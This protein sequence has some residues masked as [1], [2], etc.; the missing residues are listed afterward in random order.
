[1]LG[2]LL[3]DKPR[4]I[5]SHDVVNHCRR[6]LGTRRVGH[7]GTLDPMAEGLL[8]VAVGAATRF[9]QYLPLEPKRYRAT[10]RFG[11]STDSYDAD[12]AVTSE[13]GT[14]D[15]L[16]EVAEAA[17][18]AF[19]GLI[20]QTP[21]MYSAVKMAG[22]PLYKY[23]REGQEVVREPR[24][25]H[26]AT[27]DLSGWDG[28]TAVAEIECSGG[29]YVR[30]LAHDLGETIGTGAHLT[31][32][33]R[34]GVGRF[35]REDAVGLDGISVERLVPLR[36]ALDPM[37]MIE[38]DPAQA[39]RIRHGMPLGG[40]DLPES[41]LFALIEPGG[42]VFAVCRRTGDLLQPECVIPAEVLGDVVAR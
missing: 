4:G 8:V 42:L 31:A 14:P 10:V 13:R 18:P 32:L 35:R 40:L 30:S 38:V 22:K 19:R 3:I 41:E 6:A 20:R 28:E 24:T 26:I 7:S 27:Y 17:L 12:G 9:L 25:V 37:P 33:S 11:V 2:V 29:T 16:R 36:D 21:P 23:A 1:M 34:H 5:T 39:A 15:D